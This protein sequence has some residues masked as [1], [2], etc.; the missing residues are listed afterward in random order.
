MNYKIVNLKEKTVAGL[1]TRT[2][3][4]DPEMSRS[5]GALWQQF[6]SPQGYWAIPNKNSENTIGLYTNYQDGDEG[7]YDVLVCCEVSTAK[8][9]PE[10]FSSATI[11][12]GKYAEFVV[13]GDAQKAVGA[14]W[15]ELW[16]M[17]L[18]RKFSCDFE[19]YHN[20]GT[21]EDTEIH[22]YISLNE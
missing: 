5:I 21:P 3:N 1:K 15:Q 4:S 7:D 10:S 18:D 13:H 12:A 11:P 16:S 9:L 19:E 17:P 6:F 20:G 8:G 22:I 2:S 14:F